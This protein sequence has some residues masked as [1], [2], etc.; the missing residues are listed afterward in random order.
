MRYE[1][2]G[3]TGCMLVSSQRA[4]SGEAGQLVDN[5]DID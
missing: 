4:R 5:R 2:P 3:E 1:F